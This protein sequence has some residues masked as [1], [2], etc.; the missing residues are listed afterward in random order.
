MGWCH[1]V[2]QEL[3]KLPVAGTV[4]AKEFLALAVL[5]FLVVKS[6]A[7]DEEV[8]S[9]LVRASTNCKDSEPFFIRNRSAKAKKPYLTADL[10]TN[11]ANGGKKTGKGN[12]QWMWRECENE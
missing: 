1:I 3:D 4:M 11:V 2:S 5:I 7:K 8:R 9:T 12:Q 6:D 10:K